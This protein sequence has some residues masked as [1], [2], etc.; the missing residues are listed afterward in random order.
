M[1]SQT[2]I[3]DSQRIPGLK[4]Q[5]KDNLKSTL[6]PTAREQC[7]REEIEWR[8]AEARQARGRVQVRN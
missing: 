2:I 6:M 5:L 1:I 7:E 8:K 4:G 3:Q